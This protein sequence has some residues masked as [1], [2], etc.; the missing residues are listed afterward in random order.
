[1]ISP[2]VVWIT[3]LAVNLTGVPVCVLVCNQT[4]FSCF[5]NFLFIWLLT[6][7]YGMLRYR[8]L[9]VFPTWS[10]LS[11]LDVYIY[12]FHW[13]WEIFSYSFSE[14]FSAPT[15]CSPPLG[16]PIM[17]ML[18]HLNMFLIFLRLFFLFCIS[19]RLYNHCQTIFKFGNSSFCQFKHTVEHI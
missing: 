6:V 7:V 19:F 2:Y 18:V 10:L 14:Y 15:S 16:I 12:V 5:Q 1:M 9:L 11:F 4:F 3:F 8:F 13:I 17:H